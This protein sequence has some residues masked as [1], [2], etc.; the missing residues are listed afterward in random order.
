M[1]DRTCEDNEELLKKSFNVQWNLSV[2]ATCAS[3]HKYGKLKQAANLE[4][5]VLKFTILGFHKMLVNSWVN[6]QLVASQQGLS[7]MELVS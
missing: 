5:T 3:T 1:T 6:A 7:S 4:K 2:L